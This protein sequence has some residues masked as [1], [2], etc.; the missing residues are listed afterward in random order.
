MLACE[1]ID[2]RQR[3]FREYFSKKERPLYLLLEKKLMR[4]RKYF[5]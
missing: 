3:L 1:D 5:K 2:D 4:N